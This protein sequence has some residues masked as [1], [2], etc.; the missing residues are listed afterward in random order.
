MAGIELA[1]CLHRLDRCLIYFSAR[2]GKSQID[3]VSFLETEEYSRHD[4]SSFDC[5]RELAPF[6]PGC[7]Q[8]WRE[9]RETAVH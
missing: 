5:E 1:W 6:Q 7:S 3:V 2:W 8:H 9:S 4:V